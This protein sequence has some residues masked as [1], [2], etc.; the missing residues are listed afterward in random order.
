MST[1]PA[2]FYEGTTPLISDRFLN[3]YT[4][5]AAITLGQALYLNTSDGKV[6]PTTGPNQMTFV[7]LAL[8]AQPTAG[9]NITVVGRGV[10]RYTAWGTVNP[11]DQLTSGKNGTLQTD[12]TS[13]N[14]TVVGIALG[15]AAVSSGGTGLAL[16]W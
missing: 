11:G 8:T 6:Y 9:K 1:V 2:P 5:G 7:G 16:I 14:T 4:A 13:K 12:N 10:L 3:T 15:N